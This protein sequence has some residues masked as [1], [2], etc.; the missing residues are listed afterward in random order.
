[1]YLAIHRLYS[2]FC[3][4][5]SFIRQSDVFMPFVQRS[6]VASFFIWIRKNCFFSQ[7]ITSFFVHR[8][9]TYVSKQSTSKDL[10]SFLKYRNKKRRDVQ[11]INRLQTKRQTA[12]FCIFHSAFL[13]SLFCRMV[14]EI[15]MR[16]GKCVSCVRILYDF[17]ITYL[18]L[19]G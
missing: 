7:F 3:L 17:S 6:V 5:L 18:N 8:G 15:R 2:K 12:L 11:N 16:H 10:A 1:M 13:I 14:Y 9:S 19:I 4:Y